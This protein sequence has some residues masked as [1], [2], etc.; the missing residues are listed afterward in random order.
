MVLRKMPDSKIVVR[1][2]AHPQDGGPGCGQQRLNVAI[3]AV[4]QKIAI[5]RNDTDEVIKGPF[6]VSEIPKNI[7][8]VK[9]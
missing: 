9:L 2:H 1:L 7:T 8:M 3:I 6:K 5:R 4:N